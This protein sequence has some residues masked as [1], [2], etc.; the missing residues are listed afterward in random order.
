MVEYQR[1]KIEQRKKENKQI[2]IDILSSCTKHY[3][4]KENLLKECT[5]ITRISLDKAIYKLQAYLEYLADYKKRIRETF[6][7]SGEIEEPFSLTL[8]KDHDFMPNGATGVSENCGDALSATQFKNI[9]M[10]QTDDEKREF[11]AYLKENNLLDNVDEWIIAPIWDENKK[12]V[13]KGI[14]MKYGDH[15]AYKAMFENLY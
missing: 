9:I 15:C 5:D 7:N 11:Q 10:V 12:T 3:D 2:H 6:E 4:E 1:Q 8:P 13:L 14:V